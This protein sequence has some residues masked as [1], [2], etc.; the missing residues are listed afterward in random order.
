LRNGIIWTGIIWTGTPAGSISAG[1][2][3]QAQLKRTVF[4]RFPTD[5]RLNLAKFGTKAKFSRASGRNFRN[6]G[7][8]DTPKLAARPFG[9]SRLLGWAIGPARIALPPLS[10]ARAHL[11]HHGVYCGAAILRV[12][13]VSLSRASSTYRRVRFRRARSQNALATEPVSPSQRHSGEQGELRKAFSK[14]LA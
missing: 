10:G 11:I 13:G 9:S 3:G 6:F 14:C 4:R 12:Q 5:A 8:S 1:S 2:F 7:I